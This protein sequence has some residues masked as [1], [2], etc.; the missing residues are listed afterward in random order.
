M[1]LSRHREKVQTV[2][3]LPERLACLDFFFFFK[4]DKYLNWRELWESWGEEGQMPVGAFS[5]VFLHFRGKIRCLPPTA[6]PGPP[7]SP[8]PPCQPTQWQGGATESGSS[9]GEDIRPGS[10]LTPTA[11]H[12]QLFC[13]WNARG[14][15]QK[16]G[17]PLHTF[18]WRIKG[19]PRDRKEA[20]NSLRT[21]SLAHRWAIFAPL[22]SERNLERQPLGH[23]R[24]GCRNRHA[25]R[26]L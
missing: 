7:A 6:S 1:I 24:D 26:A 17:C 11:G 15:Q 5:P 21:T 9:P 22:Q 10:Y 23:S 13:K 12:T 14:K 19:P 3:K 4:G 2:S 25:T 8:T 16:R 18:S 20:R